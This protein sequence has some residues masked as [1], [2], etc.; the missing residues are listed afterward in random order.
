MV[1]LSLVWEPPAADLARSKDRGKG[2]EMMNASI[3]TWTEIKSAGADLSYQWETLSA[4]VGRLTCIG[5]LCLKKQGCSHHRR[6]GCNMLIS[7][8]GKIVVFY[9]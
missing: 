6:I 7:L 2:S 5:C 3:A 8:V 9:I 4:T 1:S